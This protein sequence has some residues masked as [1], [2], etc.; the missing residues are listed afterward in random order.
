MF[1]LVANTSL[2]PSTCI[3]QIVNSP[4][5]VAI[6]EALGLEFGEDY[7]PSI[8][9]GCVTAPN[10]KWA[11]P[12]KAK[13]KRARH[14]KTRSDSP[15]EDPP[16][17]SSSDE[18]LPGLPIRNRS[19]TPTIPSDAYTPVASTLV[20]QAAH[21]EEDVF[22]AYTTGII[23]EQS[24]DSSSTLAPVPVASSPAPLAS[25]VEF[26]GSSSAG[27]NQGDI[28]VQVP[29]FREATPE[30]PTMPA[31][32]HSLDVQDSSISTQ[33]AIEDISAGHIVADSLPQWSSKFNAT[34]LVRQA[35]DQTPKVNLA[36]G[37]SDIR[38]ISVQDDA[39]GGNQSGNKARVEALM[40]WYRRILVK[41]AEVLLV[42]LPV[43]S[44]DSYVCR[45]F[46]PSESH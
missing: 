2:V 35:Q 24:Q 9:A 22:S 34:Y 40:A 15:M 12:L 5:A 28:I 1:L 39:L 26:I 29:L 21:P 8:K 10:S 41:N 30:L 6:E 11:V 13:Q 37:N 17:T 7:A 36:P 44:H 25:D 16:A 46:L 19:A 4:A 23:D 43:L 3:S 18:S 32:L 20:T 42:R 14:Q 27:R 38:R 31:P 45:S 33:P